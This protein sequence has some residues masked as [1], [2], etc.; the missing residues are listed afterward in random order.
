MT[1]TDIAI[2]NLRRRKGKTTFL[3]LTFLLVIGITVTLNTLAKSMQD[4]LQ[5][6]L[7]E[8]GANVVITPKSEHFTLSYGGLSVPGVDYEI[9]HLDYD[10]FTTIQTSQDLNIR[11]IAPKIIGSV[12]GIN[13]RYLIIGV[14]FPSELKIKPW[15]R[16][17]GLPPGDREVIIG[18]DLARQENLVVGST[19]ELNYQKYPVVGVM[20][21][22]GGSEDNG[23]FTNFTTSRI[24]TGL[25]SWS[26][27]ELNTAEPDKTAARMN[28][29]L[30]EAKVAEISQLV[31]GT[32]ESVD[33]FSSFSLIASTLLGVI[34]VLIVF[35]TTMGNINDRVAEI[36][37]FRAIGFRRRHILSIL[38]REIAL[39]SLAGGVLGY[40]LGEIAPT[41]LG[42]IAFQKAVSFQ[43]HPL[44]ALVAVSAS[45]LIGIVCII[46]PAR[47]A[48]Q[49]DP[50]DA[51][52]YI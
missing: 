8:Y 17:E 18:S 47:R 27:I 44:M 49:L 45:V 33:R 1:L 37:V 35:V 22:T 36:G 48:V 50:L 21:E 28:E 52:S 14:D 6:S 13:K 24:I 34:G 26:M 46:F 43:F 32:K 31:Q 19:L 41:L 51:L 30:P 25:D 42:P 39:V 23:V 38:I 3:F 2:Q 4:D 10:V 29:L 15:W 12:A 7:T 9:K 11:E 16:I 20:Q 40:L 5:K